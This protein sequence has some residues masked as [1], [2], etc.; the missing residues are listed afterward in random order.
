M[1][2]FV[3]WLGT[4]RGRL[5]AGVGA[6]LLVAAIVLIAFGAWT[7]KAVAA[8]IVSLVLVAVGLYAARILENAL[9]GPV[10]SLSRLAFTVAKGD[11]TVRADASSSDALGQLARALN[12][13]AQKLQAILTDTVRITQQVADTGRHLYNRNET[14]KDVLNQAAVSAGELAAGANQI[15]EEV[16]RISDAI[17][18][19]EK[20][21]HTY[22]DAS[23]AMS[24]RSQE[25]L[26]LIE[27]GRKAVNQQTEG[28]QQNVSATKAVSE[29]IRK[30]AQQ[31]GGI[32]AVT[33]TIS[34]IADQTNLLA[35]NASIEAARA[36]EHGRGFAVVAQEVR[37]L[38]EEAA[39]STR[40]VFGLVRSIEQG[41]KEAL[42]S[43]QA[44]EAAV[45]RQVQL[46]RETEGIFTRIFASIGYISDEIEQF[47]REGE[48]MLQYARDIAST[49]ENISAITEQ[50]AAGTQEVSASM[51]EQIRAVSDMLNVAEQMTREV[52]QLQ[53][54][55][56]VFRI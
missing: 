52:S 14:L 15:S 27:Q 44:N 43:M 48:K 42:A 6:M 45:E 30:L 8:L 5:Y 16:V 37:K 12:D 39:Q 18:E 35:L 7:G 10:S 33:R 25:M 20:R 19:I 36:G 21:I 56:S 1:E 9:L 2:S 54:T 17:R 22:A 40:E 50:S 47:A 49:M 3:A 51:N 24:A 55:I 31:A 11:F 13:M 23:R 29:T 41:I 28:V 32:S 46:I 53:R 34:E 4:F 26:A 38:S